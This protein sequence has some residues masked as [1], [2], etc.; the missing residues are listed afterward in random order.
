MSKIKKVLLMCT[1]YVLVA[2]LAIGGTIA[3]LQDSDSDVNVMTLGNVSIAQH[4]YERVPV[5]GVARAG[6]SINGYKLITTDL[7]VGYE[8]QEFTQNKPLYPSMNQTDAE[9]DATKVYLDQLGH[10]SRGFMDVFTHEL[11]IDKFVVI[12]NTGKSSAYVRTLIAFELGAI[13]ADDWSSL[14]MTSNHFTW[15][16]ETVGVISVNENNY[17]V[18]E[19]V[20]QGAGATRHN[21]GAIP[22]GEMTYNSLAQI[23][24]TASA[25]NEDCEALDGNKN[26]TYDV[27][28]LSQ[29]VQADGFSD[30]KTALDTGFGDATVENAAKWFEGVA[31][32]G[33]TLSLDEAKKAMQ[34]LPD[35]T[36]IKTK[37]SSIV[38]GTPADY[39]EIVRGGY[40][41]IENGDLTTYY[42]PDGE[43]YKVYMLSDSTIYAPEDSTGLFRDMTA[44]KEVDLSNL[45]MSKVTSA[46]YLFRECSSLE[47]IGDVSGWDVS[48]MTTARGMFYNC[49][50]LNGLDVSNWD[51]SNI[52]DGG[53]MFY[54]C[55]SVT[56]L[57]VAN[58]DTSSMN[59]AKSMFYNN[60][61][62]AELDV[63]NWDMSDVTDTSYMFSYCTTLGDIDFSKWD[64]SN[65]Q[66]FNNMFKH[67]EAMTTLD[68][69][70]WDT[71]S[72]VDM[73]HMF[74]NCGS[75][76]YL[77]ISSFD[78][79]NVTTMAW[80]F[81]EIEAEAI[82]VGDNWS[83]NS[84]AN[85]DEGV[86]SHKIATAPLVGGEGTTCRQI[87]DL[88]SK[89]VAENGARINATARYMIA[90][91]GSEN[92]GLLTYKAN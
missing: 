6:D 32:P 69:S 15:S 68:L 14:V 74:A 41:S 50:K 17:I 12:E 80:M 64:V 57:D 53:W 65:V 13:A 75:L 19:Y 37:V 58:W 31:W 23:Y 33:T 71:S 83:L 44:L 3:Y 28:V 29:A 51:V 67:A 85:L 84:I 47:S 89:C 1:A 26:G 7:G 81:Y 36:D 76:R 43:N 16:P 45:D 77:D 39:P 63:S 40:Q 9:W 66:Y 62:V 8:L 56:E 21:G 5:N 20:Y 87:M 72:A 82:Y 54:N 78:T 38:Y 59:F 48:N 2:A 10:S 35:G 52:E 4:E 24:M 27:L 22:G 61:K 90:D 73:N 11:A 25:T 88:D 46:K 86:Y 49:S 79:S 91:G 34:T 92:P 55:A 42:V 60:T 30:A 70:T 18:L